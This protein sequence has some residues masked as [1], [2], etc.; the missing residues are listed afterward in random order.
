MANTGIT[1]AMVE[2]EYLE[3]W[4]KMFGGDRNFKVATEYDV[5]HEQL[6]VRVDSGETTVAHKINMED[7]EMSLDNFAAKHVY[8]VM[9]KFVAIE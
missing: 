6:K 5:I 9:W 7:L 4:K 1:P 2:A 8:P 3:G